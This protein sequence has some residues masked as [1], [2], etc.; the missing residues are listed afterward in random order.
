MEPLPH[1]VRCL[2]PDCGW[3]GDIVDL[4]EKVDATVWKLTAPHAEYVECCPRC[5]GDY[6][7]GMWCVTCKKAPVTSEGFEECDACFAVNEARQDAIVHE[8][9]RTARELKA[10]TRSTEMRSVLA[11]ILGAEA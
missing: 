6:T 4:D 7:E 11:D 2:D 3:H 1:R 5:E 10:I 9:R 8:F